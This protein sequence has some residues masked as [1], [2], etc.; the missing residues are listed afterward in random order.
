MLERRFHARTYVPRC[1]PTGCTRSRFWRWR[2]SLIHESIGFTASTAL[3]PI[4]RSAPIR[5]ATVRH[6]WAQR[7]RKTEG[8]RRRRRMRSCRTR[9]SCSSKCGHA[10]AAA[11]A[12]P[13]VHTPAAMRVCQ[14]ADVSR[15]TDARMPA[16]HH[17]SADARIDHARTKLLWRTEQRLCKMPQGKVDAALDATHAYLQANRRHRLGGSIRMSS[18]SCLR[19]RPLQCLLAQAGQ[20][21]CGTA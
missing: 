10:I 12:A 2:R 20:P 8:A 21:L 19:S 15:Q 13:R 1:P 7:Q 16:A 18:L 6:R 3:A 17:A 9:S 5:R 4:L 11:P 14:H